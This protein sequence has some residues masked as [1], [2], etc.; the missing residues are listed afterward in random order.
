MGGSAMKVYI[1]LLCLVL[2]NFFFLQNKMFGQPKL[3]EIYTISDQPYINVI[4]DKYESDSLYLKYMDQLFI[5]HQDSIKYLV[6]RNKSNFAA[7][8]IIGAVVGGIIGIT[9]Y[10]EPKGNGLVSLDF[11]PFT[12]TVAG[13]FIGGA[14]GGLA[15]AASGADNKY[16][17]DKLEPETK[18]NY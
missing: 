17:I 16:R 15:G 12:S 18:R 4:I 2:I 11:G 6:K 10:R 1:I 9:T 3:W 5:I 7:G 8:C 13:I 14:V